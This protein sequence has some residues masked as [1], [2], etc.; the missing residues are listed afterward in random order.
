MSSL[1]CTNVHLWVRKSRILSG[2]EGGVIGRPRLLPLLVLLDGREDVSLGF[3]EVFDSV[4]AQLQIATFEP[5]KMVE[6]IKVFFVNHVYPGQTPR[7][8]T[9]EVGANLSLC[10]LEGRER[11]GERDREAVERI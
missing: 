8:L 11:G 6:E 7:E 5:D 2:E 3:G 10:V 4:E 9:T 1:K